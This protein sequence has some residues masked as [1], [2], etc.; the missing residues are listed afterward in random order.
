MALEVAPCWSS[1]TNKVQIVRNHDLNRM[2]DKPGPAR[3]IP[4]KASPAAPPVTTAPDTAKT[5]CGDDL[6]PP[7]ARVDGHSCP[8]CLRWR[9]VFAPF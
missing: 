5:V 1:L 9:A 4:L 8:I 2:L 6:T 3:N 7:I